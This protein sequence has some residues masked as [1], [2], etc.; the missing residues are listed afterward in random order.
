[1]G[2][3]SLSHP[4]SGRAK[5]RGSV[6]A[7]LVLLS[8]LSAACQDTQLIGLHYR[9]GGCPGSEVRTL[10]VTV[11]DA[12]GNKASV[13]YN[14]VPLDAQLA[15]RL[16]TSL[17]GESRFDL[18]GKD[19]DGCV[20]ARGSTTADLNMKRDANDPS[21]DI[22]ASLQ[23]LP[24]RE[25]GNAP[26]PTL[27]PS[28]APT[29]RWSLRCGSNN[30]D[31]GS[32]VAFDAIGN[33]FVTGSFGGDTISCK[34][35]GAKDPKNELNKLASGSFLIK[36][37]ADGEVL[38]GR[39][40][41]GL[42]QLAQPAVF[43]PRT[44]VDEDGNAFI[45]GSVDGVGPTLDGAP[46][47]LAS[48]QYFIAKYSADGVFNWQQS[49]PYK[50]QAV[51]ARR[52]SGKPTVLIGGWGGPGDVVPGKSCGPPASAAFMLQYDDDTAAG[53]Q[54]PKNPLIRCFEGTDCIVTRA[55]LT[56]QGA[57]WTAYCSRGA[58]WLNDSGYAASVV[59]F[60]SHLDAAL[61]PQ[62]RSDPAGEPSSVSFITI[63]PPFPSMYALSAAVDSSGQ[64]FMI[65]PSR[66][67]VRDAALKLFPSKSSTSTASVNFSQIDPAA[68]PGFVEFDHDQHPLVAGQIDRGR[69]YDV[70]VT[71]YRNGF[72]TD[73]SSLWKAPLV[74]VTGETQHPMGFASDRGR[75]RF[76]IVSR[77]ALDPFDASPDKPGTKL[78]PRARNGGTTAELLL[79]VMEPTP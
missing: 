12:S 19:A 57:T 77:T 47:S 65:G 56:A 22:M 10:G 37:S 73:Q 45:W 52:V 49:S 58:R 4:I 70:F 38:W 60:M 14:P 51:S 9:F 23:C 59:S 8:C 44:T 68:V 36:I 67:G 78:L 74:F 54:T 72:A 35:L 39:R 24:S 79:V 20:V 17:Q 11:T 1:M 55:S 33:V 64:A 31:V 28:R 15:L 46:A 63:S 29:H 2:E 26:D 30:N 21:Q 18:A 32:S 43:F 42:N 71:K 6:R 53:I 75:N 7:K 61:I 3:L 13:E 5:R 41:G 34:F 66:P 16:P 27:D 25:C 62:G 48:N 76:A 50:I 40:L 69:S